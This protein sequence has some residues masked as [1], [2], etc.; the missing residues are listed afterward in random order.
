MSLGSFRPSAGKEHL[1]SYCNFAGSL[2]ETVAK[3]LRHS[4]RSELRHIPLFPAGQTMP[5]SRG[6]VVEDQRRCIPALAAWV[7]RAGQSHDRLKSIGLAVLPSCHPFTDLCEQ[8][9]V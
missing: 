7:H 2:V 5:S 6:E 1:Y 4:C 3:S 9:E 8:L